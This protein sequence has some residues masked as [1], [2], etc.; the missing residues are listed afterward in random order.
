MF[1]GFNLTLNSTDLIELSAY[2][3]QGDQLF[4]EQK[5][6]SGSVREIY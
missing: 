5:R 4:K 3:E 6:N 1:A 2:K